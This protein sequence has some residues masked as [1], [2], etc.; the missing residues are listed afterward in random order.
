MS[1]FSFKKSSHPAFEALRK[2]DSLDMKLKVR[3]RKA[4]G[5]SVEFETDKFE[6]GKDE[7]RRHPAQVMRD[8]HVEHA[9]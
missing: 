2:G 5:D 8:Y 9:G 6:L 3:V 1:V 4:D 7:V